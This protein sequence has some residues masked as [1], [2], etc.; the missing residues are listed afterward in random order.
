MTDR[1]GVPTH[2][3]RLSAG[4]RDGDRVT[5]LE[6]F[7]DLVFVLAITQC[8]TLMSH[9]PSWSGIGQGLL[10]LAVL[11]WSWVGYAWLTSVVDPEEGAVRIVIFVAMAGQLVAALCVPQAFGH[12]ALTFALSYGVVRVAHIALFVLASNDDPELR[13]SVRGLAVSTTVGV[14]LL[15]AAAFVHGAARPILWLVA[16]AL[17]AGAP[18]FFWS[19]GWRLEPSHFAER[20]GLVV[21]IALGESIIALGVGSQVGVDAGVIA[22]AVA[23]VALAAAMWWAYFDVGAIL[24]A[25]ALVEAPTG[26]VQ[27]EMA[28]DAYSYLHYPI[29]AGIVLVA[30][31]LE[32]TLAHHAEHLDTLHATALVGGLALY[33]L[34]QVLFKRRAMG[35]T[36][37]PRLAATAALAALVPLATHVPALAALIGAVV[38]A[39]VLVVFETF[40]FAAL[41]DEVRH[42]G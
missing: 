19:A 10:A 37:V 35:V 36:S 1:A 3:H 7:F 26:Q 33:F 2:N 32:E 39:W 29:V 42:R 40:H 30:L 11:W 15:V 4:R 38:V 22:A 31:G 34:A 23:G 8:S 13:A 12:L 28:R 17:D 6:L 25:R 27:N 24:A 41:R 21:L 9:H 20:H 5:P 18:Y 16:L 14:G